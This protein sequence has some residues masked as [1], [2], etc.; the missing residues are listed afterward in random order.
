MMKFAD[1]T[2]LSVGSRSVGTVTEV[3][4]NIRNWAAANIML[5]HPSKTKEL[6]VYRR[7]D[8]QTLNLNR[9][10]HSK[11]GQKGSSLSGSLAFSSTPSLQGLSSEHI[12]DILSTCASS[13]YALRLVY[14]LTTSNHRS[15]T[16]TPEQLH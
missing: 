3:F 13:T 5:I 11:L 15:Y 8:R 10:V 12:N 4:G 14:D 9:P 1:D 7:Q 2:Y 6:V 16:W